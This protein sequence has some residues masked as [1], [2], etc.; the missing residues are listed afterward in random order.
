MSWLQSFD[1]FKSQVAS[2]LKEVFDAEAE[3]EEELVKL[4]FT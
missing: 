3:E 1:N 2:S 4:I